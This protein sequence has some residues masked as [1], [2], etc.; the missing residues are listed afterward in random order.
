MNDKSKQYLSPFKA[1]TLLNLLASDIRDVKP[2]NFCLN[3]C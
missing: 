3:R 2:R 1:S